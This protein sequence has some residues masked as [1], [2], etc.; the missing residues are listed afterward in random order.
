MEEGVRAV[1]GVVLVQSVTG[2]Y[3]VV[4][5]VQAEDLDALSTLVDQVQRVPGI[6]RTMTC[7]VLA[8]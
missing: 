6:T 7:P 1:P 2:P 5:R 4:A 3:D 8:V